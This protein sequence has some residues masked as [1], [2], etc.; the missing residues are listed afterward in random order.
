M[1]IGKIIKSHRNGCD[2]SLQQLAD[3]VRISKTY[4]HQIEGPK[5]HNI[6]LDLA[7]RFADTF[8]MSLDEMLT[9]ETTPSKTVIMAYDLLQHLEE[10]M[11]PN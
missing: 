6:S 2:W 9:T 11:R 10:Q 3:R 4:L 8:A 1:D 5:N 7:L